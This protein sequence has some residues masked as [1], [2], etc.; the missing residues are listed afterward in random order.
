MFFTYFLVEVKILYQLWNEFFAAEQ[1]TIY[2][3][4]L[5][6]AVLDAYQQNT[7]YPPKE[8]M[9][10]A[11]RATPL[12]EIKVVIL[13]QDPYHGAGQAHGLSFSVQKGQ[14]LPPS[15]RNMY[16][17]LHSDLGVPMP[18]HGC[19]SGWAKQGVFLLNAALTVKEKEP[20]SH[21]DI[22]EVFTD[23]VID[24]INEQDRPI[25]FVLWGAFAQKKKIRIDETKHFV[26]QS[27][28]PSPFSA[29]KG[30]LG[31]KPYSKINSFLLETNQQPI[32]WTKL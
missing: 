26:I 22:W 24:V 15:L 3:E 28:H 30:F 23:R 31:S 9:F 29:S 6:K 21:K 4:L 16:I 32:D 11:F 20:N 10:E 19:L 1:K 18:K 14:S 5:Q 27:A 7:V 25:C 17:E 12:Q 8:M 2:Y 13:G